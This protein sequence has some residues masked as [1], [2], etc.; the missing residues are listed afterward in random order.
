[1]KKS[2]LLLCSVFLFSFLL[3]GCTP[4][5][6]PVSSAVLSSA[7]ESFNVVLTKEEISKEIVFRKTA[8]AD[9]DIVLTGEL[10]ERIEAKHSQG[11]SP[12][13]YDITFLLTEEGRKRLAEDSSEIVKE[14]QEMS[15][16]EKDGIITSAKMTEPITDGTFV[17]SGSYGEEEARQYMDQF[18]K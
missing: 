3:N 16:W 11:P 2:L 18:A 4:G 12:N 8:A 17:L 7:P 13:G 15:I 10:I 14:E 6:S 1:M 9:G 5:E